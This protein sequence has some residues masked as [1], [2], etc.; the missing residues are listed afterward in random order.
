MQGI[1]PSGGLKVLCLQRI[2]FSKL[3]GRVIYHSIPLPRV[4][5]SLEGFLGEPIGHVCTFQLQLREEVRLRALAGET[6]HL[7]G[8]VA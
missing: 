8:G 7:H 2:I 5:I 4:K 1:K 3:L 6:L